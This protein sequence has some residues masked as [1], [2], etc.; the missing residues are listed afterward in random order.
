MGEKIRVGLLYGGKSGEHEVSLQTAL[1]VM[2]AFDYDKYEIKPFYITKQGGWYAGQ[3]LLAAPTDVAQLQFAGAQGDTGGALMPV[4]EGLT[5][6]A[7][8]AAEAGRAIDVMFPLLH[9]TFGE[10][11]TIQG[12]F[13]MAN[14]PYVG[15][16]VLASAVGM[17]KVLMK[18]V[19]AQEGLPQCIYRHFNR[20]QWEK[21]PQFFIMEIEVAL[22][23]PCFVKPANLGSSVGISKAG[24]REELEAAVA[25][26]FRYDRK[27]IVEEFVDAREIEVSVLGND[28][29][30]AS[31]PGEVVSSND[32]YDY[33]AKYTDGKSRM[34]IPADIPAETAEAVR[35]MAVRAFLAIDGSGLS[36]VDFFMRRSDGQ[37]LINEVNTMPGF[38]PFSMYPLMWKET[39]L[40]Y[41]E[42]LDKLIQLALERHS[43]KQRIDYTGGGSE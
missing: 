9:G 19:F 1:A 27:V 14:M 35:E 6:P 36:R 5:T 3:T 13:E 11:G 34:Q 17:D 8:A 12:L 25:C 16:G 4:F 32:F 26:A 42:L 10:D 20:T 21:D 29:P 37:L 31:V 28:E 39:G 7:G 2:K 30:R 18:K 41:R 43:E 38:T 24:N 15:A 22:G 40:P 33:K 23:Y